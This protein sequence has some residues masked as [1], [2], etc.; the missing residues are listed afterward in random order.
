MQVL[1]PDAQQMKGR[2]YPKLAYVPFL[3]GLDGEYPVEAN[4]YLRERACLEWRPLVPGKDGGYRFNTL[5]T[6]KSLDAMARRLMEFLLWCENSTPK[7]SWKEVSYLEDLMDR[8]QLGMLN[9]SASRSGKK[10]VV[11]TVNSRISEACYFL[12]WAA[13]RGFRDAFNVLT[14]AVSQNKWIGNF[15]PRRGGTE[16]R[17]GALTSRRRSLSLPSDDAVA[18]WHSKL[19]IRRGE[20]IG[21]FSE[22]LIRTGVRISEG[23][24]FRAEDLPEK[25]FG[26]DGD[27]WREDW[28][29]SGE[30]PCTI[31][32]G[33]KGPKITRGSEESVKSRVIYIPI[34]LADRMDYY[35]REGRSTLIARWVS[36]GRTKDE[37]EKRRNSVKTNRFWLGKRGAPLSNS[38]VRQAWSSELTRPWKWCPHM[39]RH[40]FAVKTLVN[41][42]RELI[43]IH[44]V[45]TI[46]SV[47]W[48]HGLLAG[49]ISIILT[50]LLGHVSEETS[51]LYLTAARERLLQEFKHPTLTWLDECENKM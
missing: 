44:K 49:Q 21:L 31:S 25:K 24:Q 20:V 29:Q 33:I 22:M 47:G 35:R 19:K 8:W 16:S 15:S 40:L 42:T 37:R 3:I 50:P 5:Q 17:V 6:V 51:L 10:L 14:K 23:T 36:A 13:E 46:P 32:M 28:L 12:S 43:S 26:P 2:G 9:G 4:R 48:L 45:S 11:E 7:V 27:G 34:D 18:Q 41:Y 39:A 30:V 38:W 1:F